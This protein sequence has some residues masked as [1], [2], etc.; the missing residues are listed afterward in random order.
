MSYVGITVRSLHARW[1]AHIASSKSKRPFAL[2]V[3]IMKFGIDAFTVAQIDSAT[4]LDE[5][6]SLERK[7]IAEL[8]TKAPNGYN[9]TLGGQ[10]V[11]GMVMPASARKAISDKAK[12][13]G[14]LS[15]ETRNKL[16]AALVGRRMLPDQVLRSAEAR[17]GVKRT[18]EQRQ[19]IARANVG[20][21]LG[22]E[23]ARKY[24]AHIV[25][26]A[27]SLLRQGV[28][29]RDVVA[30]TGLTQSYVSKL[31]TGARGASLA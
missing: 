20:K 18:A 6:K 11:L 31:N 4:T 30:M 7:Y 27:I 21:N 1:K 9:K 22:N 25:T 17:R 13:R 19:R 10:G 12:A 26:Y 28:R 8:N 2:H 29:G 16:S 3:D 14:P 5:L 23:S 15:P 24:P